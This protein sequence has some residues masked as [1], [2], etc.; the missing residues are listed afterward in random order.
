M[1]PPL[2]IPDTQIGKLIK[3]RRVA[4]KRTPQQHAAR[5]AAE[6]RNDTGTLS[7]TDDS[8][9]REIRKW[10]RAGTTPPGPEWYGPIARGI[11][12]DLSRI[13]EACS[14]VGHN[15]TTPRGIVSDE[16]Q[17]PTRTSGR[18]T[19]PETEAFA[20][21][22]LIDDLS[23]ANRLNL[24]AVDAGLM[25]YQPPSTTP[26]DPSINIVREPGWPDLPASVTN[27]SPDQLRA[28]A[29]FPPNPR[30]A[31]YLGTRTSEPV[32]GTPFRT[33]VAITRIS[34][35]IARIGSPL[36]LHV[37]PMSY[38]TLKEFNRAII[39]RPHDA[40]LQ[41][42]RRQ[43][44][45]NLLLP[46][47]VIQ[48]QFPSALYVEAVIIT[49]DNNFVIV[50]KN[51]NL[52]VLSR[53]GPVRWTC[54]I[55]EGAEW[56]T[57]ANKSSL[58]CR[59]LLVHGLKTEL[60]LNDDDINKNSIEIFGIALEWSH[61]NVGI[62]GRVKLNLTSKDLMPRIAKSDDFGMRCHFISEEQVADKVFGADA[63]QMFGSAV[64]WHPTARL[65]ILLA[66]WRAIG[67]P[68]FLAQIRS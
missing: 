38:W 28:F 35:P 23:L 11:E 33:K 63:I 51:P 16:D 56:D 47:D 42:I 15:L 39:A 68:Q 17:N 13:E 32:D 7:P 40:E 49:S 1:A 41:E 62:L 20:P 57:D 10:G 59:D 4:L 43:S 66:T 52:S 58:D 60:F 29:T 21:P 14:R 12:V 27:P 19:Y 67:R 31:E 48:V 46:N 65:R 26:I 22:E 37:R 44:I 30:I 61:L 3:A 54:T 55:E 36:T 8:V 64:T 9:L 34:P 24:L 5:I 25:L 18:W 6:R 50:E 2:K 53:S 45:H